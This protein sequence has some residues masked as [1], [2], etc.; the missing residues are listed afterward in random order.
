MFWLGDMSGILYV[1]CVSKP[2]SVTTNMAEII[3]A[4]L[5]LLPQR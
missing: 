5:F 1:I 3:H 2:I 4:M